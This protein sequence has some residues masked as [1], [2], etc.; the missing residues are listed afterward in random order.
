MAEFATGDRASEIDFDNAIAGVP[1]YM[2]MP[3]DRRSDKRDAFEK[4]TDRPTDR[5]TD[6][7]RRAPASHVFLVLL[8]RCYSPASRRVKIDE[9]GSKGGKGFENSGDERWKGKGCKGNRARNRAPIV[10]PHS[11]SRAVLTPFSERCTRGFTRRCR[12][13]PKTRKW[14]RDKTNPFRPSS[15]MSS[16][17]DRFDSLDQKSRDFDRGQSLCAFE[18][19]SF[20]WLDAFIREKWIGR[21]QTEWFN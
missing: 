12:K 17:N 14:S 20:G 13:S 7:F 21:R 1:Y 3:L 15:S 10:L 5:S 8:D 18:R 6:R 11:L 16:R 2:S 4:P 9:G 19:N